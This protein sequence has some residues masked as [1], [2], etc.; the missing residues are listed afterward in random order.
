MSWVDGVNWTNFKTYSH[1]SDFHSH[2]TK[3]SWH[4]KRCEKFVH[5]TTTTVERYLKTS[6]KNVSPQTKTLNYVCKF[7]KS[8]F[9]CNKPFERIPWASKLTDPVFRKLGHETRRW[10]VYL[11]L[12]IDSSSHKWI[13]NARHLRVYQTSRIDILLESLINTFN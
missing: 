4:P 11:L 1:S 3:F 12:T 9:Q 2:L 8:V 6:R 13:W 7:R 10:L 5:Y